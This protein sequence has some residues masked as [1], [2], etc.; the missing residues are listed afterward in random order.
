MQL[1]SFLDGEMMYGRRDISDSMRDYNEPLIL[2]EST[3]TKIM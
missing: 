1:N 3:Q 2:E